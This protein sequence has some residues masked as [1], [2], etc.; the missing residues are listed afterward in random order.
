MSDFDDA[1]HRAKFDLP[2]Q[3]LVPLK[4]VELAL[5]K[6]PH[7]YEHC[8]GEEIDHEWQRLKA[9]K[10]TLFDGRFCLM[11][12]L[13]LSA[14]GVLRGTFHMGRY[15]TFL[16]WRIHRRTGLEHVFAHAVPVL[17]DDAL[18]AVQMA[19]KT[20][21]AG[22]VYFPAGSFD[23][24]DVREGM[25]DVESN[26]VREVAEETGIDLDRRTQEDTLW[27][28]SGLDGAS[29]VFRRYSI[30]FRSHEAEEA[31]EKHIASEAQPELAS[32][33]ILRT[34]G[35]LPAT[36]PAHMAP[37]VRFHFEGAAASEA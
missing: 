28:W 30:P 31:V 35:D 20:A 2:R 29:C 27:L 36:A 16:H 1:A 7:P 26:M 5:V 4:A 11:E 12:S 32:A 10:P 23:D 19:G 14:D 17:S 13:K 33:V 34:L 22:R 25:I 9:E 6:G 15:A 21:N 8:H 37:F 24:Q 18:L 3:R